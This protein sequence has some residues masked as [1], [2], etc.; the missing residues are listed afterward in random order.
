MAQPDARQTHAKRSFGPLVVGA[1]VTLF[2]Y[3]VALADGMSSRAPGWGGVL[4]TT[5]FF[6]GLAL[7]ALGLASLWLRRLQR[8][9]MALTKL[10][11]VLA[12]A[13][14]VIDLLFVV[15]KS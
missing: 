2:G 9:A 5:V 3:V 11:V 14:F 8:P 7:A 1:L 4:G 12:V 15:L 13:F 6:F 10:V